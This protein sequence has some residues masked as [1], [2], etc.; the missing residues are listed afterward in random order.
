M[1]SKLKYFSVVIIMMFL[2]INLSKAQVSVAFGPEFGINLANVNVTPTTTTDSRTGFIIGGLADI[3]IGNVMGVTSG[4]RFVMKGYTSTSQGVTFK[5][6][7]NYLEIPILLKA[8][9]PLTEVKPYVHGGPV[10]GINL[11]A[12]EEQSNGQQTQNVDVSNS[13]ESIDFGLLFGAGLDFKIASKTALFIQFG[14]QLGLS[15]WLKNNTTVTAKNYG[16]QIT[17]GA[18]FSL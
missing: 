8:R 10:L 4:L 14:Y 2:S 12:T 5:E 3:N 9:F 18:K 13:V 17:G 16:I 11:A 15:N 7:F 1:N 6:K